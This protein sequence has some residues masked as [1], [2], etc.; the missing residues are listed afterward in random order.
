MYPPY[1]MTNDIQCISL[2]ISYI[3]VM[4]HHHTSM[5]ALFAAAIISVR[6]LRLLSGPCC[7][8]ILAQTAICLRPS[9]IWGSISC[10]LSTGIM[11]FSSCLLPSTAGRLLAGCEVVVRIGSLGRFHVRPGADRRL[12]F[13]EGSICALTDR[14]GFSFRC[15][16]GLRGLGLEA[17]ACSALPYIARSQVLLAR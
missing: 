7:R 14:G 1:S 9:I 10:T 6:A 4:S 5:S 11:C 3:F 13:D 17:P 8:A 2:V 16:V 15:G 12:P